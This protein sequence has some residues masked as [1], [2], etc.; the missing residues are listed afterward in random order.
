[1]DDLLAFT[2]PRCSSDVEERLYGPC[3]SCREELRRSVGGEAREVEVAA[4]EPKVNVTPN[5][6]ATKDD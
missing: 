3:G 5:H 6:V 1:M 4:Y 2:C